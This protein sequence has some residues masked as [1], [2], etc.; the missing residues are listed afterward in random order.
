MQRPPCL[1][2]C[3]RRFY[4]IGSAYGIAMGVQ[5]RDCEGMAKSEKLEVAIFW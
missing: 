3:M 5:Q 1:G 4:F 2:G